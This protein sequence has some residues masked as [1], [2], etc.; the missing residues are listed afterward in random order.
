MSYKQKKG[1]SNKQVASFSSSSST[2]TR[3][4]VALVSFVALLLGLLG[5][6]GGYFYRN[7][8]LELV[9]LTL[10]LERETARAN[11]ADKHLT[12]ERAAGCCTV[13]NAMTQ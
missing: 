12:D 9:D 2:T 6:G 3:S 4:A 1:M 13:G 11:A 8:S 10:Q 7:L 5:S